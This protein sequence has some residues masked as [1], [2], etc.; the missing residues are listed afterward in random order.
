MEARR[1][2]WGDTIGK[3][4]E[5]KL[6]LLHKYLS[7]YARI[8][9]SQKKTWLKAYHSKKQVAAL[10]DRMMGN[11]EWVQEVYRPP[12]QKKN[13]NLRR[14]CRGRQVRYRMDRSN[15]EPGDR[16]YEGESWV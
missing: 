1:P 12:A 3:W 15:L 11:T 2:A 10:L 8:M 16:L 9:N 13:H 7:A 6:E 14:K 4:P 5:E